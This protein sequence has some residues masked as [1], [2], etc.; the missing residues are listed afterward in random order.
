MS[1]IRASETWKHFL[2]FLLVTYLVGFHHILEFFGTCLKAACLMGRY[3]FVSVMTD[4]APKN[5]SSRVMMPQGGAFRTPSELE[6]SPK[7]G[8]S[9]PRPGQALATADVM[10]A[11]KPKCQKVLHI[12]GHSGPR[13]FLYVWQVL[14]SVSGSQ[15]ICACSLLSLEEMELRGICCRGRLLLSSSYACL[16]GCQHLVK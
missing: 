7:R 9:V 8:P 4:P 6:R 13:P 15:A 12:P 3:S 14:R 2:P 11:A 16:Q 5:H 1:L 10:L